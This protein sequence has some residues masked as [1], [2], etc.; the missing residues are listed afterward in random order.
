MKSGNSD[1]LVPSFLSDVLDT[2]GSNYVSTSEDRITSE[3]YARI[4]ITEGYLGKIS[5]GSSEN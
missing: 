2:L 4:S 5:K 3:V 1:K